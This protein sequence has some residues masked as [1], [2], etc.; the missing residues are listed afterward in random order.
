MPCDACGSSDWVVVDDNGAEFP[1]TRIEEC[2]CNNCGA[3]FRNV[4]VA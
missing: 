4:L 2:K 1:Q 3:E